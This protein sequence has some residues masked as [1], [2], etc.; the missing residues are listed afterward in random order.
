MREQTKGTVQNVLVTSPGPFRKAK[1]ADR[2]RRRNQNATVRHEASATRI[3][4]VRTRSLNRLILK[5]RVDARLPVTLIV[6]NDV[7]DLG[8]APLAWGNVLPE[9][10]EPAAVSATGAVAFFSQLKNKPIL[11]IYNLKMRRLQR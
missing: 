4:L 3:G 6:L 1:R 7:G 9:I 5:S 11:L 10:G 2:F 8:A